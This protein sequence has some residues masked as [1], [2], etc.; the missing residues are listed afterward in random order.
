M[1][2]SPSARVVGAHLVG[3]VP[4]ADADEVF[5]TTSDVLADRLERIPDGETG[6]RHEWIHFQVPIIA[7]TPGIAAIEFT[8][9]DDIE[10][11]PGAPRTR[12]AYGVAEGVDTASLAFGNL[13]YADEAIASYA[14]FRA[15]KD[16]GVIPPHMRFQVSLPTTLAV[17]LWIVEADRPA[18]EPAYQEA[19]LREIGRIADAIPHDQLAVQFD[20]CVEVFMVEGYPMIEPWFADVWGGVLDRVEA[21]AAAVPDDVELGF[22]LCYGDYKGQRQVEVTDAANLVRLANEVT[23]RL[24]RPVGFIQMPVPREADVEAWAP[25]LADLRLADDTRLYLGIVHGPGGLA[26]AEALVDLCQRYVER[27]GVATECGIGRQAP[28]AVRPILEIHRQVAAAIA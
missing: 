7:S 22:H 12:T 3:S 17:M 4:L 21:H 20:L 10:L 16:E 18:I 28:E 26:E 8:V 23:A 27:F 13:R 2:T 11:P 9:P 6:D 5:R 19:L 1:S 25:P 24:P 15:L 14:R